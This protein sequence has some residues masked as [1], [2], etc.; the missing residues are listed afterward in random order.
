MARKATGHR[1]RAKRLLLTME[2]LEDRT[3]L[4]TMSWNIASGGDWDVAGN[5]VNTSNPSD[6]HAPTAADDAVISVSGI[7]VTHTQSNSDTVNSLISIAAIS[8]SNGTLSLANTSSI[9]SNFAH[10]LAGS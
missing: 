5:W 6:H 7:S 10:R 1:I 4:A 9:S 3:L 8:L 2:P